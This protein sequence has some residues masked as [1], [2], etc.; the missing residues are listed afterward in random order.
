MCLFHLV[1]SYG[2]AA[3]VSVQVDKKSDGDPTPPRSFK[4]QREPIHP[5]P[6]QHGIN[7]VLSSSS[8]IAPE[9]EKFKTRG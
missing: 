2:P 4:T 7:A 3:Q 8:S 6:A 9:L 1:L 5:P